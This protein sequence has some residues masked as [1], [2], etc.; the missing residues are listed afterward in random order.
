M[1]SA[2]GRASSLLVA[3]K[4]V[5]QRIDETQFRVPGNLGFVVDVSSGAHRQPRSGEHFVR[6]KAAAFDDENRTV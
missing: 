4:K 3:V 1:I 6:T 2:V 5:V